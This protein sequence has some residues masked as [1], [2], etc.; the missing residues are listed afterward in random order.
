MRR[1]FRR[2][3]PNIATG[4]ALLCIAALMVIL[5]R[6]DWTAARSSGRTRERP[7]RSADNPLVKPGE[8]A[9]DFDLPKLIFTTDAT[10]KSVGVISDKDRI[11]LSSFR[12]KKPVCLIMSSYT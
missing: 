6:P 8:Y 10:G 3:G 12:G 2:T 11:R 1:T 7:S 4:A 9:P 5:S